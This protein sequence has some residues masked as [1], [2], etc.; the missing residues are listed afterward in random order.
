YRDGPA[1]KD[2]IDIREGDYVLSIDGQDIKAGDDYWKILST[3]ENDYVPVKVS[4][5]A[6]GMNA[7]TFRIGAVNSLTNIKYNEWVLNNRDVVDKATNN[8]IAYV[9]IRAM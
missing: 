3:T 1:D 9:H 6:D 8:D 5:T 7:K 4:R 2:W